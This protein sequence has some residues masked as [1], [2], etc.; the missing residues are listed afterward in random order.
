MLAPGY[1]P[2]AVRVLELAQRVGLLV[3]VAYGSGH[4]GAVS[5]SE[6]AARGAALRPVER[7]ARR[8][9]VAAYNAYVEG[10]EVRR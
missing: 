4:G 10:G 1:P 9:Q 3:S 5:A 6:I 2:R 8:A 7:V